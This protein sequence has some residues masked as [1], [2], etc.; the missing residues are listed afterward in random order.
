MG[1]EIRK[2]QSRAVAVAGEGRAGREQGIPVSAANTHQLLHVR[3]PQLHFCF[4][5][6]NDLPKLGVEVPNVLHEELLLQL[7]L[8]HCKPGM[9]H[10]C[11]QR[12]KDEHKLIF[13]VALWW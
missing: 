9:V 12:V 13:V 4:Q 8:S 5:L 6:R 2:T 7:Q 1:R 3:P 10:V 11:V